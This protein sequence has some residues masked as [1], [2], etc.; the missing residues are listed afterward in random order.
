VST[1]AELEEALKALAFTNAHGYGNGN[2][3]ACVVV[4]A[5]SIGRGVP[6]VSWA[7]CNEQ[8]SL[9]GIEGGIVD[10]VNR[11]RAVR[12]ADVHEMRAKAKTRLDEIESYLRRLES[13][14]L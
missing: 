13:S 9:T 12:V 8:L 14:D 3:Y 5:S 2:G 10:A 1:I 4:Q 6:T 7:W 11:T